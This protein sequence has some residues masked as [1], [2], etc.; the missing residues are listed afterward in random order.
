VSLLGDLRAPGVGRRQAGRCERLAGEAVRLQARLRTL[1]Q[2]LDTE[3][4][5]HRATARELGE[6]VHALMAER[7]ARGQA[8]QLLT[9]ALDVNARVAAARR[10]IPAALREA[11]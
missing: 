4:A 8:E 10:P 11:A 5:A 6:T 1:E 9:A 3:L 2:Q 7:E